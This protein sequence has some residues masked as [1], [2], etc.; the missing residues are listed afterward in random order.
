MAQRDALYDRYNWDA[1]AT[2]LLRVV[3]DIAGP[4]A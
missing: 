1:A 3:D 4:P 2:R